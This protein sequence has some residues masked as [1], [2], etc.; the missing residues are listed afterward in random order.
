LSSW[1]DPEPWRSFRL[2]FPV[3]REMAYLNHAAVSPL[4]LRCKDAVEEYLEELVRY[5]AAKYPGKVLGVLD[6][7][8]E[9][10]AR[11]LGSIPERIFIVRST[12]QGL[13]IVATGLP[14]REGDNV[15]LVEREFPANIRPWLPLRR[16]GVEVRMVPQR[17]GRIRI[18]D[19]AAA[20]DLRTA[21]V[22]VSFVQFLSGF[23]IDLSAVAEICRK[24]DALC[25]VDA[26]Q[27]LGVFS[28][29]VE[30]QGIDFVSADAHKWLLGPEGVGLGYASE[31]ALGRIEPALEG[32][33]ALEDPFDFFNV[34]Q[35][36][37]ATAAR[38]EEGAY[39]F[40]GI[41][42][43]VGSLELILELGT[44]AL[45][46]RVLELTDAV[47]EGLL[48][49]GWEIVSPRAEEAEKSGIVLARR[50]G[51]DL[52][53]LRGRLEEEGVVVSFR[54]GALRV[55]PHGYNSE[56]DLE[57]LLAAL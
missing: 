49:R 30:A 41:H 1:A 11:L 42:G 13:G 2:Q 21:A 22:S 39:N 47:A 52:G 55:A 34:E 7:A 50:E 17:E 36:L 5:G 27:G 38:Y 20:V 31:R 25:V 16:R 12:T 4:P 32:W 3:A 43:L 57:R 28:L 14:V 48:A 19:L 29:D 6:R 26:I 35:P 18:E 53:A 23:R 15:V 54:G 40:A 24:N 10:G 51:E 56:E 37:K 44:G 33:F 45:S 46:R 8:R 9:L